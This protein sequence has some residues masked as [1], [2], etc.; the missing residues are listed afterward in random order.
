[1]TSTADPECVKLAPARRRLAARAE[2]CR[3]T[4]AG[5]VVSLV[6]V[7]CAVPALAQQRG[8]QPAPAPMIRENAT[9]KLTAHVYA[10]SDNNVGMVPN[11]GIIVGSRATLV[12][13]TG[14]GARNG[15]A[16]MREVAKVSKNAELYLVTTH[17]HPEHDLGAGG[18]PPATRMIRSTDQQK[19]I[20]EFG[21]ETAKRFAGFS[22]LNAELLQGAEYRRADVTFDRERTLDLGGVRV[23]LLAMGANHTGGDTAVFVESD[24]VLFSGDVVMTGL[25]GLGSPTSTIKQWL[26]SLDRFEALRPARIVP[27]HGPFGDASM[28]GAYRAFFQT[29]QARVAAHKAQGRSEDETLKLVTAEIQDKYPGNR[30]A[31]AIRAAYREAP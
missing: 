28:I 9:D 18:F 23:R 12:V 6:G 8:G 4:W 21:L 13:D 25:P 5:A 27:S 16:V 26:I 1:M 22:P 29:V 14:L 7:G 31:S 30:A 17:F 2:R 19:D 11:V 10:I 24:A 20:A 15:Q 3:R